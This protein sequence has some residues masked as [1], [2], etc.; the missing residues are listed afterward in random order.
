MLRSLALVTCVLIMPLGL[1][2]WSSA[3]SLFGNTAPAIP[4]TSAAALCIHSSRIIGEYGESLCCEA[5]GE[6]YTIGGPGNSVD[7]DFVGGCA[8]V[9]LVNPF[10]PGGCG[11]EYVDYSCGPARIQQDCVSGGE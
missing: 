6:V 7:I 9:F 10:V 3:S 11:T 4:C 8:K 1:A 5:S 2:L